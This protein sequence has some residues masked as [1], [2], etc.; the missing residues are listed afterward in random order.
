MSRFLS[1]D[2]SKLG[3]LPAL[4]DEAFEG[5]EAGR[6]EALA[7]ALEA[8][9]IDFDTADSELEP[10]RIAI[11]QGGGVIEQLLR[12]GVNAAIEALSLATAI[13]EGLDHI[14][15]T[16]A[17][18]LTRRSYPG[19][20]DGPKPDPRA[21]WDEA[22]GAWVDDD[23]AFRVLVILAWEAIATCGPRGAY[24]FF[25]IVLDDG[26]ADVRDAQVYVAEDG[27]TWGGGANI[28][29]DA[30][31]EGLRAT[32][33]PTIADGGEV[34]PAYACVVVLP[35]RG[36]DGLVGDLLARVYRNVSID[37]RRPCADYVRVEAA[38]V[39][40]YDIRAHLTFAPGA[41][42]VAI[43]EKAEHLARQYADEREIVGARI[44]RNVLGG[45]IGNDDSVDLDLIEPAIDI[46]PGPKG[47]ARC[48]TIEITY[49]IEHRTPFGA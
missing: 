33:M 13:G 45:R 48:G 11:A 6:T 18:G 26:A 23:D 32:P 10:L 40:H 42:A 28:Y 7:A 35:W 29:H 2:L 3:T 30:Y 21:K 15:A 38:S 49:S 34:L 4:L 41:D 46:D 24:Q 20:R 37:R 14:A 39:H 36:Y 17:F 47:A 16:Y 12:H 44:Q 27:A 9:G 25:A 1:P 43:V 8:R 19:S 31:T 5:I 22:R